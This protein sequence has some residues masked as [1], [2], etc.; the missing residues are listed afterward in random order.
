MSKLPE[1]KISLPRFSGDEAE[2]ESWRFTL[3][4]YLGS[5]GLGQALEEGQLTPEQS[6]DVY[7]LIATSLEGSAVATILHV[8]KGDGLAAMRALNERYDS[9]R[10]TAKFAL[11]RKMIGE[12]CHDDANAEEW[13]NQKL[14]A[15]RKLTAMRVT[16]EE[17]AMLGIVDNLPP[18]MKGLAD[19]I[20]AK[21]TAD[22]N[23][24]LRLVL[25]K[26]DAVQRMEVDTAMVLATKVAYAPKC[27]W[28]GAEGHWAA[29][30][31][32]GGV[33]AQEKK[34]G[35]G[36]KG[37]TRRYA[38]G[39]RG[40]IARECTSWKGSKGMGAQASVARLLAAAGS[41]EA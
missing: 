35:R 3:C 10:V 18:K 13:I 37:V 7:Y 26:Q 9:Q 17:V 25:E 14:R 33:G 34:G 4:A 21:G 29:D 30:C 16:I 12:K 15:A 22:L 40:H 1:L 28:R 41:P 24:V 36:G 39:G 31:Q 19:M 5:R 32:R 6:R 23:E 20:L 38:C 8:A 2:Y 11:L 27:V